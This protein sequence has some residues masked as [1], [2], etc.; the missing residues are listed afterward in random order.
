MFLPKGNFSYKLKNRTLEHFFK[1]FIHQN[2]HYRLE[3]IKTDFDKF[4]REYL[5]Y[6]KEL[7][8]KSSVIVETEDNQLL[9]SNT[10][11]QCNAN[12]NGSISC[13]KPRFKKDKIK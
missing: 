11:D 13:K 4:W 5:D 9:F 3:I 10:I 8:K 12:Q 7:R 1:Q 2:F 6:R